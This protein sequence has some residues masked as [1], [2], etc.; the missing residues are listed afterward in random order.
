MSISSLID[1]RSTFSNTKKTIRKIWRQSKHKRPT[2]LKKANATP[3]YQKNEQKL[4]QVLLRLI[5]WKKNSLRFDDRENEARLTFSFKARDQDY[6]N[7]R[8]FFI[9]LFKFWPR[10]VSL[11]HWIDVLMCKFKSNSEIISKQAYGWNQEQKQQWQG[12]LLDCFIFSILVNLRGELLKIIKFFRQAF[13]EV[14][15]FFE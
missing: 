14:L 2:K 1:A 10:N 7:F 15:S 8:T 4:K 3:K 9:L 5:F 6:L 12:S 13:I 11:K